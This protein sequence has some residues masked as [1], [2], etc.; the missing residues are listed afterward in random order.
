MTYGELPPH[1]VQDKHPS[2]RDWT[3]RQAGIGRLYYSPTIDAIET[4]HTTTAAARDAR[5][6]EPVTLSGAAHRHPEAVE[7]AFQ[8]A[9][10]AR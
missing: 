6:W 4:F 8:G 5:G 3:R 10:R 2:F 9:T 7:R 1:F